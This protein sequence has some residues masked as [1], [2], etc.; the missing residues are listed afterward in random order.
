MSEYEKDEFCEYCY[1]NLTVNRKERTP[2]ETASMDE[3]KEMMNSHRIYAYVDALQKENQSLKAANAELNE[4]V[5]KSLDLLK[6]HRVLDFFG[7]SYHDNDI[8]EAVSILE[9]EK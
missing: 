6:S 5:E 2:L 1:S 4:R 8:K 3:I 9:G 7:L